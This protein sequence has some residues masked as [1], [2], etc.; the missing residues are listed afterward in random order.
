MSPSNK[1]VRWANDQVPTEQVCEV[2]QMI[3]SPSSKLRG[4][5]NDQ[6]LAKEVYEAG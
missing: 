4:G 2:G 1:S 6:V 5:A 3:M